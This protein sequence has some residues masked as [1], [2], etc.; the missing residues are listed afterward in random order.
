MPYEF[1]DHTADLA[2]RL[3]ANSAAALFEEA[4]EA[5]TDTI[6]DVSTVRP[7]GAEQVALDSPDLDALLV[8]WLSELLYRFDVHGFLAAEATVTLQQDQERCSLEATIRGERFDAE[9]HRIKVLVKA[10]TY[11][12]L[13]IRETPSGWEATVV[14]DI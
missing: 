5:L 11:H 10:I 9:R 7:T 12:D 4:A 6:C 13:A 14:V 1:V 8:D 2:V 3:M